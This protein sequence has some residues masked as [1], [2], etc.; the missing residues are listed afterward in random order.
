MTV[1]MCGRQYIDEMHPIEYY[2]T[3]SF[4]YPLINL[5]TLGT[6][7]CNYLKK[8]MKIYVVPSLSCKVIDMYHL[9]DRWRFVAWIVGNLRASHSRAVE[10]VYAPGGTGYKRCRASFE[11]LQSGTAV[12]P[13]LGMRTT[14]PIAYPHVYEALREVMRN[15]TYDTEL[16]NVVGMAE[17]G[18]ITSKLKAVAN[19]LC[20]MVD[21]SIDTWCPY[22]EKW[23]R[24]LDYSSYLDA[25]EEAFETLFGFRDDIRAGTYDKKFFSF[26][27]IYLKNAIKALGATLVSEVE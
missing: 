5:E 3:Y 24:E 19:I 13:R 15:I 9:L 16:N 17:M 7:V 27:M 21:T 25:A 23:M 1:L 26:K 12:L 20:P 18:E 8:H 2:Y 14:G 11:G 6:V 4:G 10:R 22:E